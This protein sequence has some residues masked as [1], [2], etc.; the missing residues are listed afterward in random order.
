MNEELERVEL[1]DIFAGQIMQGY[2]ASDR[3]SCVGLFNEEKHTQLAR[4]C[5]KLADAMV[6]EKIRQKGKL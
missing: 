4:L 5:Y 6:Q 3:G 1:R 2:I